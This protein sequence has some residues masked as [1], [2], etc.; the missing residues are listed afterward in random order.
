[1]NEAAPG[2]L[3]RLLVLLGP[4]A[5]GKSAL[6]IRLAQLFAGEVVACD[7]TQVYRR[8]DIGTGKVP[9][10][11]QQ[12]IPHRMLDLVEPDEVFTAGDYRRLAEPVLADIRKR[13]K[14]PIVTAGTGLYLRALLEGLAE[15]PVRCEAVREASL[16]GEGTWRAAFASDLAAA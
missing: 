9:K 14:L 8:F 11:E 15:A 3:P 7:S 2:Y 13:G 6:A 16:V 1:M 12:G 4:T 5:S 10:V